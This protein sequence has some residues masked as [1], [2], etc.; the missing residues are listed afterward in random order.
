MR[1]KFLVLLLSTIVTC[2]LALVPSASVPRASASVPGCADWDYVCGYIHG[3]AAGREA[4]Q[5]GL[6]ESRRRHADV[7]ETASELGF[8]QAFEHYRPA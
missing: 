8:R 6:C 2:G 7:E 5:L 3:F 4:K 1:R